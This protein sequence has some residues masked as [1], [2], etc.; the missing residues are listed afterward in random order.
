MIVWQH[1]NQCAGDR[2]HRVVAGLLMLGTRES[3]RIN[4]GAGG[5]EDRDADVVRRGGAAAFRRRPICTP[6]RRSAMAALAAITA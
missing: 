6:S 1:G 2:H 5:A 3:A 4:T